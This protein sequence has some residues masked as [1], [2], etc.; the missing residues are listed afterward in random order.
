M[1]RPAFKPTPMQRRKVSIA[2][3]GGMSH[4]E[5]ALAM[6]MSRN[7]LE[8]HFD[9]ELS[10]GAYERRSEVMA[11]MHKAAV[12]GNVAAQKAYISLVPHVAAPP[13]AKVTPKGKKAQAQEDAAGAAKGTDWNELLDPKVTPIRK[14][15]R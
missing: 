14:A 5:I 4:E 12:K 15:V 2:A 3:G 13:A 10:I 7:T 11:A 8:K 9:H 1:A 6:G